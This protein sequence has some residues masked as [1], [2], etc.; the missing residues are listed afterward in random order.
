MSG[1]ISNERRSHIAFMGAIALGTPIAI[2]V[3]ELLAGDALPAQAIAVML[4]ANTMGLVWMALAVAEVRREAAAGTRAETATQAVPALELIYT[5]PAPSRAVA[6][7]VMGAVGVCPR[8]F[9]VGDTWAVDQSGR[10]SVPIC[11]AAA[12]ALVPVMRRVSRQGGRAAQVSC[13]C[14]LAGRSLRF[15]VCPG[16]AVAVG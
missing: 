14:S 7:T 4:G 2:V 12:S 11:H 15:S 5:I 9:A 13:V 1:L 8:G 16:S 10:L 3:M 6:A